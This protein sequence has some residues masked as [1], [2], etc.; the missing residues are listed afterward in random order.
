M[1]VQIIL[2]AALIGTSLMT[3]F[4]YVVSRWRNEV[5]SE[6]V[7]INIMLSVPDDRSKNVSR[8]LAG[9]LLNYLIGFLIVLLFDCLWFTDIVSFSLGSTIVLGLSLGLI[10]VVSWKLMFF[11]AFYK[12]P[13]HKK[14]FYTQL[15]VAHFLFAV[16]VFL[17][18]QYFGIQ[19]TGISALD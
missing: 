5:Y 19:V 11:I 6:P 14:V 10:G 13:V 12:P 4:S 1:N 18:Y 7:L 3:F 8:K 15:F 16:S 17:V 9:W 2:I